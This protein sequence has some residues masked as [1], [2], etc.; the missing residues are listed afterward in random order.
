M[1]KFL[2]QLLGEGGH[3]RPKPESPPDQSH[4]D[5]N[6]DY[7]VDI[8]M[9]RE[10]APTRSKHIDKYF[11]LMEKMNAAI[12]GRQ[13][14]DAK[15]LVHESLRILPM[16]CAAWQQE[17]RKLLNPGEELEPFGLTVPALLQ[18]GTVLAL[19]GDRPGLE[20][21][22]NVIANTAELA[23]YEGTA[24]EHMADMELFGR[25][26]KCVADEPGVLQREMKGRVSAQDGRRVAT[27][28]GYLEKA[29]RIR[30]EREGKTYRLY[31]ADTCG[32]SA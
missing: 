14:Q 30:R 10:N 21:M 25:I 5:D 32:R 1:L 4:A 12:K 22:A 28:I 26:E 20:L 16:F 8:A 18:G 13:Y 31:P 6:L 29:E 23:S 24:K 7:F 9:G 3:G 11:E 2:L 15:E 19:M 17:D 27:L